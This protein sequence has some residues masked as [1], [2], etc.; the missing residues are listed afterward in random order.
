MM[1]GKVPYLLLFLLILNACNETGIDPPPIPSISKADESPAWSPDGKL[2]AF[3]HHAIEENDSTDYTGLYTIDT[4][5]FVRNLVMRGFAFNPNWN[6]NGK[7]IVFNYGGIY[8]IN[9]SGD[10]IYPIV[11]NSN[12][13]FPS[14]SPSGNELAFDITTHPEN[15]TGIY[16]LSIEDNKSRY[17]GLGRD[18]DW[19]PTGERLVYTG[20]PGLTDSETQI[21]IADTSGDNQTQLTFNSFTTNRYPS[22]SP[23]GNMIAWSNSGEIW[24]MNS[25]G[26]GQRTLTKG[27]NPS[28]SPNSTHIVFQKPNNEY[29]KVNLW[30][31]D[32]NDFSVKKL[33]Y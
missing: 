33:T 24:L 4:I 6:P 17:L 10:T 19:S 16:I 3:W 9:L 5:S 29:T 32:I 13:F 18:P 30:I 28:W 15:M 27:S 21:W 26:S 8:S 25:D 14:Y 1:Q 12:S 31:I 11:S 2:I 23:N 22:W 20:P 7:Q